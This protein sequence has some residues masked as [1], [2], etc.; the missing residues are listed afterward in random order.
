MEMTNTGS[1]VATAGLTTGV[2][3]AVLGLLNGAGGLVGAHSGMIG[4]GSG[5]VSRDTYEVQLQLIDA[6]KREAILAADLAS[7]KKM[8]EVFNAAN[9]KINSV[10]DELRTEIRGVEL[11]VDGNAAA[12]GVINAQFGSQIS[13]NTSQIAQLM[14]MT[15]MVIPNSS[16]C[17]GW[18]NVTVQTVPPTG[19]TIS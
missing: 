13:L 8:V 3:G 5:Y 10:R 7:E 1:G 15:K 6:Q 16:V 17:P 12:Q 9:D 2:I 4:G 19:T 18:G 14:N 11:K